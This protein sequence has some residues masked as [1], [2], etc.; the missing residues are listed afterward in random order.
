MHLV[1][2][3]LSY[4][5]LDLCFNK[6]A[7]EKNTQSLQL[8]QRGTFQPLFNLHKKYLDKPFK[9]LTFQRKTVPKCKKEKLPLSAK[10]DETNTWEFSQ[11]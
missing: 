3:L 2:N 11:L 4:A 8:P 7:K 6:H 5:S 9:F 10:Y 1:F